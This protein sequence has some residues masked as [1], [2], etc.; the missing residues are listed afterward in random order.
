MFGT[1]IK[2]IIKYVNENEINY[3]FNI[4]DNDL[5]KENQ[6]VNCR[7]EI[8]SGLFTDVYTYFFWK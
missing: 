8:K 3:E 5:G 6:I 4:N 1:Y 2:D 7:K